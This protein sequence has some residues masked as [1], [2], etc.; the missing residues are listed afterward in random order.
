M[1]SMIVRLDAITADMN[2]LVFAIFS[3]ELFISVCTS[4]FL[5]RIISDCDESI[6]RLQECYCILFTCLNYM[7]T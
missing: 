4:T 5:Y 1:L 2:S 7:Y 3:N 6:K